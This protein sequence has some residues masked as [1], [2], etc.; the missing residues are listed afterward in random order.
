MKNENKWLPSRVKK[1]GD[2][3]IIDKKHVLTSSYH[4]LNILVQILSSKMQ[5]Y[6]KGK[7]LDCGCGQVPYYIIY[8]DKVNSVLCVDW[9]D[10]Y[11]KNEFVDFFVDLNK[12]TLPFGENEFDTVYLN[13]VL[14]HISAPLWLLSELKRVMKEGSNLIISVPFLYSLHE[15]PYDYFR[16]TEFFFRKWALENGF[17][18]SELI[19]YGGRFD[20]I[21]DQISKLLYQ[22]I[23]FTRW[24]IYLLSDLSINSYVRKYINKTGKNLFPIGYVVVL[25]KQKSS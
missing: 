23:P 17:D 16:Y 8:K 2:K 9:E 10:S 3:F 15:I 25:T 11:H 20:V 7:A 12:E 22:K 1:S 24:L 13:D 5:Q 19:G 6:S 18:V 4:V 14:E 21:F